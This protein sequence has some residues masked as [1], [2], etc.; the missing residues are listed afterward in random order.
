MKNYILHLNKPA[1]RWDDG[2]PLGNGS[3]GMMLWGAPA[4]E[5]ITL[6]EETI[7]SGGPMN[8]RQDDYRA[9]IDHTRKLYLEG[10]EW[11]IDPYID[12]LG[13]DLFYRIKSY[14]YAGN[15][16]AYMDGLDAAQIT[17]YHR[18]LDL[19]DGK[20]VIS[21]RKDGVLYTR[22]AF[23]SHVSGLQ[24]VR[25]TADEPFALRLEFTRECTDVLD[26]KEGWIV[27]HCH[28]AFGDN[29]FRV[30]VKVETNG[31]QTVSENGLCIADAAEVILYIGIFTGFRHDCLESASAAGMMKAAKGWDALLAEHTDD[32]SAIMGRSDIDFTPSAGTDLS[33]CSAADRLQALKDDENAED[34]QL[35]S[36]YYQFGKYLLVASSREDTL[37]AN[38]QGVWSEGMNSPWNADYHTNINLQ[39]NYW[40]AEEAGLGESVQALFTYMNDYL[41]PGGKRVAAENYHARGMVVHHVSDIYG[42]AAAADGPWGMWPMGGAWLA[43]HM[44][45]HYLYTGDKEYLKNTAYDYIRENAL[46]FMDMLF[47]DGKGGLLSG[48]STSPENRFFVTDD[49]GETKSA[50]ITM[51]PSMDTEIIGGLLRFYKETEEILGLHPEDGILAGEM[52]DRLPPLTVGKHGQLME[53]ARDYDEPE[54]GHRHVSHAFGLYPAAQITRA[55]PELFKAIRVTMDR[56]LA[57]GGG[58]TGWSRA[59]L[60]N[61]FARL[62]DGEHTYKNIRALFTQSTLPNLFD[63]H[64]PFQI[65]GN[66]GGAAGIGEMVLQSHEKFLSLLPALPDKLANGSF[67]GLQARGGYTVDASWTG[68]MVDTFRIYSADNSAAD[69]ELPAADGT[70]YISEAGTAYTVK[71]GMLHLPGNALLTKQK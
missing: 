20:A 56:R 25:F 65:D 22:E 11:E 59:W 63:A 51:S 60:I 36:L 68:G 4:A 69:V 52:A 1:G 27:A 46:F 40:H 58:H 49:A 50:Y 31:S 23:S 21:F 38:L 33:S 13:S 26:Y 70:V 9:M 61:M 45:E 57:S 67:S 10:R 47:E 5:Q 48:P 14:E 41:L 3:Q 64:P 44:W 7:W 62:R 2:T 34:P 55:T 24:C 54:P 19:T 6:N 16:W 66:F 12:S 29:K 42:F 18:D 71:N 53:W 37:P 15:L 30:C 43:F 28:T 17:D 39:M 35:I 8:T 32:F